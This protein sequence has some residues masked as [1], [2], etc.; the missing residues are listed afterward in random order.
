[1]AQHNDLGDLGEKIAV[2]DLNSKG[3]QILELNYRFK[4]DEV[5]IIAQK[6]NVIVFVEVKTRES[7]YL[8]RPEEAVTMA[9][10][11]RIIK[12]ANHYMIENN[13][14]LEGRFDIFG[15]IIN[16]NRQEVRHIEDAFSPQW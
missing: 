4:R 16:K 10:Q 1:M 6:N 12:V 8:G 11:K 3:Y 7:D 13:L 15:I 2:K 5:D 14:E 9:K